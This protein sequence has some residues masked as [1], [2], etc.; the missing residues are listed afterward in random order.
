MIKNYE[1]VKGIY[2]ALQVL[3]DDSV[4]QRNPSKAAAAFDKL[5]VN[6]RHIAKLALPPPFDSTIGEFLEGFE[7]FFSNMEK[8]MNPQTNPQH[9]DNWNAINNPG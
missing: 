4:I 6:C 5:F 8:I 1:A 2:E 9:R 7:T 3:N